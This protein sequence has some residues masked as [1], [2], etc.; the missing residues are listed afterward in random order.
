[1]GRP[2]LPHRARVAVVASIVVIA[3][4]LLAGSA[5]AAPSVVYRPPVDG[6]IIDHFRPP[7]CSWCPGNRGIDYAVAP[8]T[9]VR[10]SAPG[11]VT[12][13]GAIGDQRFVTVLHADGLRTSYAYLATV[14][15]HA[16]QAVGHDTV[17]GTSGATLH[18]GVRRGATYLDPELLFAGWRL[19]ARLVPTNGAPPR[20][21]RLRSIV[22]AHCGAVANAG[23][24]ARAKQVG[25][26]EPPAKTRRRRDAASVRL[27]WL[28]GPPPAVHQSM[29][30]PPPAVAP[31]GAGGSAA[32]NRRKETRTPWRPSSPCV[33]CSRR[34]CT[35]GTRPA[36][37]TRR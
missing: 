15:V 23:G 13:A 26:G 25:A 28:A 36:G 6:P 4:A 10:A 1:M 29:S 18:F 35:S 2:R 11:V 32:P 22:A 7:A 16:G 27:R 5:V 9:P 20:A 14:A 30:A 17:V 8:G 34:G 19:V 24:V 3:S 33:S 21:H 12:F 37:G 31:R